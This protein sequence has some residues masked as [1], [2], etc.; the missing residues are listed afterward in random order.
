MKKAS[1]RKIGL[2]SLKWL[3]EN[4]TIKEE[5]EQKI[6]NQFFEDVYWKNAQSV[7]LIRPLPFEFN[8]KKVLEQGWLEGKE[9]LVPRAMEERNLL[10]YSVHSDTSYNVSSLGIEEPVDVAAYSKPIDLVIVPGVVFKKSGYRIGYGGGYYDKYLSE[11]AGKTCSLVFSEQ[12]QENWQL[13]AYDQPV[14]KLFIN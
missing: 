8:M 12:I 7:A 3:Q 14:E 1:V 5:K 2:A 13:S 10:F 4:P 11:Y 6:L 9:M